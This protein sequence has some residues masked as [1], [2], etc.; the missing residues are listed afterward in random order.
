MSKLHDPL[1]ELYVEDVGNLSDPFGELHIHRRQDRHTQEKNVLR[2]PS[3]SGENFQKE[4]SVNT[5]VLK[6]QRDV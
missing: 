5:Y 1:P 2:Q 3:S 4:G 6:A